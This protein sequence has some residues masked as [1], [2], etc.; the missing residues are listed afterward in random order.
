M[1]RAA[2]RERTRERSCFVSSGAFASHPAQKRRSTGRLAFADVVPG[3][4]AGW[5]WRVAGA[6]GDGAGTTVN[7]PFGHCWT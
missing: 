5:R 1:E 4:R 6:Y 3:N 7:H 2:R